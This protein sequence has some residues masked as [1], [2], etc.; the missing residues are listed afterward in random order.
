MELMQVCIDM[1]EGRGHIH[2]VANTNV[3][4]GKGEG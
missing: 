1:M 4:V 2:V 3:C